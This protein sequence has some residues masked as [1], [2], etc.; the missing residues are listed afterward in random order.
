MGN[1]VRLRFYLREARL[2]SFQ[3]DPPWQSGYDGAS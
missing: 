1:T 3:L 2:Y